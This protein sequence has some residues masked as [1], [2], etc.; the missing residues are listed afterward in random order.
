MAVVV[1]SSDLVV[2]LEYV[3]V[4]VTL[5]LDVYMAEWEREA[6]PLN[7]S[8][9]CECSTVGEWTLVLWETLLVGVSLRNMVSDGPSDE[10]VDGAVFE[11]VIGFEM[12][13]RVL[14][15]ES[16]WDVLKLI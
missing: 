4:W 14:D 5:L 8:A 3:L 7:D 10:T 1:L 12:D 16:D 2:V 9:E 11:N 15:S 6:D 13:A